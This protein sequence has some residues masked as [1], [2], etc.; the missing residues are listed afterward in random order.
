MTKYLSPPSEES[1]YVS[2]GNVDD[3]VR[4]TD[5]LQLVSEQGL[6]MFSVFGQTGAPHKKGA[7]TGQR[8]L[9]ISAT[10]SD[11]YGLM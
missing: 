11:L 10:I 9:N 8:M 5:C 3:T 1:E 7:H 6:G 2:H 4:K